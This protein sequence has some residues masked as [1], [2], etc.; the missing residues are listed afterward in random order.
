MQLLIDAGNTRVKFARLNPGAGERDPDILAIPHSG[1]ADG[2]QQ[3]LAGWGCRPKAALGVNVAGPQAAQRIEH[4][5]H[6][7]FGPH[8]RMEW[9][10]SQAHVAG[11][12]NAYRE[13]GRL[14]PDRWSGCVGVAHLAQGRPVLLANFGTATTVDTVVCTTR[15]TKVPAPTFVGGLIFPGPELMRTALASGTANLPQ[16]RIELADY[17]LH[18]DSAIST[19]IAAAQAGAVLRQWFQGLEQ[20]NAPPL[21]VCSGG[22]WPQVQQELADQLQRAQDRAGV[23]AVPVLWRDAPVLDGL[24]RIYLAGSRS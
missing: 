8:F 16:A 11:V 4:A 3:A 1:L 15:F 20:H 23:A 5:L 13:P 17:P 2:L 12:Y 24:A 21:V 18:T 10:H 19:G 14:G 9:I 7:C 6:D 22:G